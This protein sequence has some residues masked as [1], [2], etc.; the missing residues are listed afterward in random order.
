VT[1]EAKQLTLTLHSGIKA[2]IRP[3]T[4]EERRA[5]VT[6]Q[7]ANNCAVIVSLSDLKVVMFAFDREWGESYSW[8]PNARS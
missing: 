3:A 5:T 6:F 4:E 7:D 1:S 2:I 8:R